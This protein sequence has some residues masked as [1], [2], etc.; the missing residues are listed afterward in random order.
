MTPGENPITIVNQANQ[1]AGKVVLD[2]NYDPGIF[3]LNDQGLFT[4]D[5]AGISN[6]AI[7]AIKITASED[8]AGY[9]NLIEI[10]PR[11]PGEY[12]IKFKGTSL[13][14]EIAAQVAQSTAEAVLNYD[15]GDYSFGYTVDVG[16]N[17]TVGNDLLVS[18]RTVLDGEVFL[19][20]NTFSSNIECEQL[21]FPKSQNRWVDI[22]C[23][24]TTENVLLYDFVDSNNL[25]ELSLSLIHI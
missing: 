22:T 6:I 25:L 4:I 7:D 9:S 1:G 10:D 12:E 15:S 17:L 20:S 3:M 5:Y 11:G 21:S 2:F 18:G 19:N 23:V 24:S 13:L 8:D 16:S 14:D